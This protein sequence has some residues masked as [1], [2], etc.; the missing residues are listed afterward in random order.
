MPSSLLRLA[1]VCCV[2]LLP[3]TF[4]A[5]PLRVAVIGDYGLAGQPEADVAALVDSWSPTFIVTTG[6]NN[7]SAGAASTID[8]NVGQYYHQY[9]F[10]YAGTYGDGDTINRFFPSLGNHDWVTAGAAPYLNFFTL[11]GNERYYDFAQGPVHFFILDT[12]SH[13]PD[14]ISSGSVQGQWLRRGLAASTAPWKIV[15]SHFPPYT[16]GSTHG[17]SLSTR[18]P[19]PAWGASALLAGHEHIYERVMVDGFPYIVNGL[20]GKSLYP[21]GEPIEGSVVRYNDDYGAMIITA[22]AD[23]MTLSFFSRTGIGVDTLVLRS[24][25]PTLLAPPDTATAQ[26]LALTLRWTGAGS[27]TRFHLQVDDDSTFQSPRVDDST[28]V[29]GSSFTGPLQHATTWFWRVR[30]GPATSW[31]SWS[32]VRRF[33]TLT[34]PVRQAAVRAGWNI[35]SLPLVPPDAR[36]STLFPA[37]LS[38]AYA[39][40]SGGYVAEDTLRGSTGYWLLF[41]DPDSIMYA[42]SVRGTDSLHLLAGWNLVGMIADPIPV[43]SVQ[44]VP[45]GTRSSPFFSFDDA[46]YA[47]ADTLLP[48]VGY[49]VNMSAP[50]TLILPAPARNMRRE[51]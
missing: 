7:Y 3:S 49:W 29:V 42:G 12:D 48:G 6:D 27:S 37:A 9:I 4:T 16:S 22:D 10:P 39:Y 19:F 11:P 40:R 51:R 25:S 14:G 1:S 32:A 47:A 15:I 18:W 45:P 24:P 21:F 28:L 36:V 43:G 46:E 26:P 20:G 23:S 33:T 2:L 41:G 8:P 44:A 31:G 35:I 5:Q 30:Q 50:G 38:A 13:E 34:L 17:S